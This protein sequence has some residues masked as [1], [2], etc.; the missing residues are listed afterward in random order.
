MSILCNKNLIEIKKLLKFYLE[1]IILGINIK[2][3]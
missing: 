3:S 1:K 2:G